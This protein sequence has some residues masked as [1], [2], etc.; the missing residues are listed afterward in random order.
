MHYGSLADGDPALLFRE[1]LTAVYSPELLAP[2]Q[3]ELTLADL[4]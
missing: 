1:R 4:P 2:G 3:S